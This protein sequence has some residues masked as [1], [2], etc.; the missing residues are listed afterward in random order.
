MSIIKL[1]NE[2]ASELGKGPVPMHP[3]QMCTVHNTNTAFLPED[4]AAC[5][6]VKRSPH[7]D[8]VRDREVQVRGNGRL[9]KPGKRS[10]S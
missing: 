7:L 6:A 5:F 8:I 1:Q 3:I 9:L 10:F 4:P 2:S